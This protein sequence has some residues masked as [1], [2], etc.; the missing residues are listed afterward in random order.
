MRF[1]DSSESSEDRVN[2][3]RQLA[4]L[5]RAAGLGES[6]DL[7]VK[8]NREALVLLGNDGDT[9]L[10][11]DVLRWQGSVSNNRGRT[12]EAEPLFARSLEVATNIGYD[13]GIAHALNCFASLAQRRGNVIAATNLTSDALIAAKRCGDTPLVGMV[14][15]NL[16]MIADVRGNSAAAHAHYSVSLRLFESTS[17]HQHLVCWVLN[18]F[19]ILQT[20]EGKS[21]EAR[22]TFQRALGIAR[23][24]G[25]V[26][27]E[28]VIQENRAELELVRGAID[29]AY[30]PL[31]RALEI[32]EAREDH[33]RRAAALKL[34][35]AY[36]RL[37]GRP[38]EGADTL[39]YAATLSAVGEDALLSAEVLYQ[40]GLALWD[41]GQEQSA[42][43]AWNGSLEAFER[44]GARPW[45][46][47]VRARLSAGS[48]GRYL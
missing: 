13:A 17:N 6:P 2:D 47:R 39:R 36:E 34:K 44:I 38:A 37:M 29:E 28:G 27:A 11:A 41:A 1:S 3:A 8:W 4:E 35:G 43:A 16:G 19:G 30:T 10:L 42:K 48:T 7:A 33:I 18:N 26:M 23:A 22:V 32:A 21:D 14:Q 15:Q 25:D 40:F 12:S 31:S 46:M 5:A 9:P 24:Q 45:V 20:K